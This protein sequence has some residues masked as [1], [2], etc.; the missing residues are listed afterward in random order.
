[1]D[2]ARSGADDAFE[3]IVSSFDDPSP[4]VRNSA[5]R[6]LYDLQADPY[7][8]TN[9]INE[10]SHEE[11]KTVMKERLLRRMLAAGEDKALIETAIMH[12]SGQRKVL[13][14]EVRA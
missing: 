7:E 2:L 12:P 13:P 11:V 9:L 3:L 10:K 1:M 5:A 8:L 6:A 4:Q 14:D